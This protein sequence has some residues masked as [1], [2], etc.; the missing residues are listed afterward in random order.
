MRNLIIL[1][2][3]LPKSLLS[4]EELDFL[5]ELEKKSLDL[6][7]KEVE[8]EAN[9]RREKEIKA[10]FDTNNYGYKKE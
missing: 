1:D 4:S 6:L 2:E 8:H 10:H 3:L 7:Q 9:K 5:Y